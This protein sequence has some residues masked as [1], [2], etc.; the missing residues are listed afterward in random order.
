MEDI[1]KIGL[2]PVIAILIN[3][4]AFYTN[5]L[6]RITEMETRI[7]IQKEEIKNLQSKLDRMDNKIEQ[8]IEQIRSE[9]RSDIKQ[10]SIDIKSYIELIVN[11]T[12]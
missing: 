4:F 10:L 1:I 8:K 7:Q 12:K 5:N 11:K 3:Y 6:K 9:L 2:G